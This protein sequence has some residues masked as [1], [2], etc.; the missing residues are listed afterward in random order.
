MRRLIPLAV[1]ALAVTGLVAPSAV[2]G[3]P[4]RFEVPIAITFPDF[5]NGFVVLANTTREAVCTDEQVAFEESVLAWEEE[6]LE[7][8]LAWIEAGN[9]PGEFVPQP[10]EPSG[11]V[12][13]DALL[14]VQQ[15]STGK[16]AIVE[17]VSGR[18]LGI[19]IWQLDEGAP[20][21]GPCLDSQSETLLGSG[22]ADVWSKDNDLFVSG[23][24]GNAFGND[25]RASLVSPDGES[26]K[27][28]SRFRLND[29]CHVPDDGPPA[30]LIDTYTVK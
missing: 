11:G 25:L 5:E 24:R 18:D 4:D 7:D 19:E 9:D 8:F 2:A 3:P 23:T 26:F 10:P 28:F 14:S 12:D 16:G 22:T 6:Y 29:R 13:G 21:I 30:C 1:G 15:K 20:G 17:R 27:Y